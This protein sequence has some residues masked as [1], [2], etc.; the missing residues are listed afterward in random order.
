MALLD[1]VS[2][3]GV[4]RVEI[5]AEDR[6]GAAGE[7]AAEIRVIDIESQVS[8]ALS[9][10]EK[11]V[12]DFGLIQSSTGEE[13]RPGNEVTADLKCVGYVRVVRVDVAVRSGLEQLD[14]S[15]GV[16]GRICEID[17]FASH[18]LRECEGELFIGLV[19][20]CIGGVGVGFV[21]ARIGTWRF[22]V[23]GLGAFDNDQWRSLDRA[24]PIRSACSRAEHQSE[25]EDE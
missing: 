12:F 6:G 9:E 5:V 2:I 23:W 7:S 10:T 15:I 14:R 8:E 18:A 13:A 19:S 20:G 21:D 25:E 1:G 17:T 11:P 24:F 16:D 3:R 22:D 4:G